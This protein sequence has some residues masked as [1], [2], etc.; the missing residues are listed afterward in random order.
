MQRRKEVTSRDTY[1]MIEALS[2]TVDCG[3]RHDWSFLQVP[4]LALSLIGRVLCC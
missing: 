4:P 1:I 2:F 3:D